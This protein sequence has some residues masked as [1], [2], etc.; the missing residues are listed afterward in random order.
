MWV[1][2]TLLFLF[3]ALL[4]AQ[5]DPADLL[6]LTRGKV[7]DTLDRLPHYMCTQT[8]TIDRAM[9]EPDVRERG[10]AACEKGPEQRNT[11]LTSSDRLRLDVA[12]ASAAEMYSWIGES[13]FSDQDLLDMVHE[14][15]IST[16]SFA[17]FLTGIFRTEGATFTYNGETI[18]EGRPLAEFGFR[19]PY[20]ESHYMYGEGKYRVVTG[21]DG[22]FLVDSK[23]GDLVQLDVRTSRLPQETGACYASTSLDYGRMRIK[24]IDFLLPT[25][26]RLRILKTDGGERE[27]RTVFSNCH[28]F[29]GESTVVFDAP[30]SSTIADTRRG[31]VARAFRIPPGLPFRV[32]LTMG[33]NTATAAAGD[34]IQARLL[35]PIQ[36]GSKVLVPMG[37]GIAARIDRL[38]QYYGSPSAVALDIK[39]ETVEIGGVPMSSQPGRIAASVSQSRRRDHTAACGTRHSARLRRSLCRFCISRCP[40]SLPDQ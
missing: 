27:N 24:G 10:S 5:E 32:A 25:A 6:L 21:Y 37:A 26:A 11:H 2:V 23:S 19:V 38:R 36:N 22:T 31:G 1:R 3:A 35:T 29:L 13:R 7:A 30:P 12:M 16:G 9:Y 4:R 20:E 33:I 39:L 40:S 14:G 17:A 18:K 15:A 28:E 8:Q 34:P